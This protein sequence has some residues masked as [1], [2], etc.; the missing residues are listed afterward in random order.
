M[1]WSLLWVRNPSLS[2]EIER[3]QHPVV[4][5]KYCSNFCRLSQLILLAK[6]NAKCRS[7][8]NGWI[9]SHSKLWHGSSKFCLWILFYVSI[10]PYSSYIIYIC[11]IVVYLVIII[12]FFPETRYVTCSTSS[13]LTS[14]FTLTAALLSK[15]Y[16]FYLIQDAWETPLRR[17]QSCIKEM[18]GTKLRQRW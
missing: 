2:Y 18:T 13:H 3:A 5:S 10:E 16:Q 1:R 7:R 4:N 17:R 14:N 15:K 11:L 12:F 6:K 9:L 8:I